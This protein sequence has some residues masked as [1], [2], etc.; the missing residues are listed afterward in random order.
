LWLGSKQ[1]AGRHDAVTVELRKLRRNLLGPTGVAAVPGS[2]D[3]A[4]ASYQAAR[5]EQER[6]FGAR[7]HGLPS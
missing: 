1:L 4:V 5:G 7:Y 2:L 3:Q 6:R